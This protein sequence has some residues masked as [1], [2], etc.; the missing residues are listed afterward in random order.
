MFGDPLGGPVAVSGRYEQLFDGAVLATSTHG[1]S[2]V[3]AV[4]IVAT[5]AGKAPAAYQK[6]GLPG[7]VSGA[8]TAT[9]RSWLTNSAITRA[10]L[11]GGANT[12][13]AYDAAVERYGEPLGPPATLAGGTV[14]QAFADVVLEVSPGR[15]SIV[16]AAPVTQGM[17]N[18]KLLQSSLRRADSAGRAV[19]RPQPAHPATVWADLGRAVRPDPGGGNRG[20]RP[21]SPDASQASAPAGTARGSWFTEASHGMS[22]AEVET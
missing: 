4:P 5:L 19:A 22:G 1:G 3:Q 21:R 15:G 2:S 6:A 17:L 9:R 8:S 7:V 11:G 13:S 20:L 14:G 12:Q 18:A 16:H 10:Y